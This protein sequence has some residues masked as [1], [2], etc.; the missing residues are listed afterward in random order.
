MAERK[1][2][3]RCG[4]PIDIFT[5]CPESGDEVLQC[6]SEDGEVYKFGNDVESSKIKSESYP[7]GYRHCTLHISPDGN[8][9]HSDGD[10]SIRE[11][12]E[13]MQQ[14]IVQYRLLV[15]ELVKLNLTMA[16]IVPA[17][18]PIKKT[19]KACKGTGVSKD[20]GLCLGKPTN[21]IIP[22]AGCTS[23]KG[24]GYVYMEHI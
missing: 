2:C 7:E 10:H 21:M 5:Y 22:Q 19:C 24:A 6:I 16:D 4:N 8:T 15:K 20:R 3:M 23:C 14:S 1:R 13:A 17:D 9:I 12:F 18:L 11:Q